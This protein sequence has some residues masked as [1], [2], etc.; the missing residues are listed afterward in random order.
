M[1]GV[2]EAHHQRR[3]TASPPPPSPA[4]GRVFQTSYAQA[5]HSCSDAGGFLHSS[6]RPPQHRRPQKFWERCLISG[7]LQPSANKMCRMMMAPATLRCLPDL[8]YKATPRS[9]KFPQPAPC[10]EALAAAAERSKSALSFASQRRKFWCRTR[11][12]MISWWQPVCPL[13]DKQ[14]GSGNARA[15]TMTCARKP[16]LCMATLSAS[17]EIEARAPPPWSCTRP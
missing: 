9:A 8:Q 16:L 10:A 4:I 1:N 17:S 5:R 3:L 2:R 12:A 13:S 7:Q 14:S 11:R 15:S 6:Q